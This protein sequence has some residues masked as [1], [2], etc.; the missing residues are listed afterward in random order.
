MGAT[1]AITGAII[2]TTGALSAG[3]SKKAA[4]DMQAGIDK[5]NANIALD[6]GE[7]DVLALR[8][9]IYRVAGSQVA[10]NAASGLASSSIMDLLAETHTEGELDVQ[11]RRYDA[12][13]KAQGLRTQAALNQF[14]GKEAKTASYYSAASSLLGAGSRIGG[15]GSTVPTYQTFDTQPGTGYD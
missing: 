15:G 11:R 10:A 13:L 7:A 5:Q 12:S 4:Y 8:K 2:G 9:N 3:A 1:L 6:Q 14:Y